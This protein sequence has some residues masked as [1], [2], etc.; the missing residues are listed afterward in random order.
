MDE[1]SKGKWVLP[2]AEGNMEMGAYGK[3]GRT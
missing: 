3:H 2:I 1:A